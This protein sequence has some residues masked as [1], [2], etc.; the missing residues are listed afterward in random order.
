MSSVGRNDR[1][2][3]EAR[4]T[5]SPDAF[6]QLIAFSRILARQAAREAIAARNASPHR[7]KQENEP[8]GAA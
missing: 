3:K 4:V 5:P 1:V 8:D 2:G 7:N 6:V